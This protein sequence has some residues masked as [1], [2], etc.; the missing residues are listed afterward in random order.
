MVHIMHE[1]LFALET[2]CVCSNVV[3]LLN[4]KEHWVSLLTRQKGFH[5]REF[6]FFFFSSQRLV[7]SFFFFFFFSSCGE[8]CEN[9]EGGLTFRATSRVHRSESGRE[10]QKFK[11][12]P[13]TFYNHLISQSRANYHCS[14]ANEVVSDLIKA[15]C[16]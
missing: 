13:A 14:Y 6:C 4:K 11:M 15:G 12:A 16:F 1:K 5:E 8:N 7:A 2:S 9:G 10:T 3:P